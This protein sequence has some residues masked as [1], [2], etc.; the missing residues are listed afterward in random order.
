MEEGSL[1]SA[2]HKLQVAQPALSNQVKALEQVYGTRLFHRGSGS[3]RLE[4]TDAGRIL[5]EK[6]KIML[7][8]ESTARNEIANCFDGTRGSLRVGITD[9]L[10]NRFLMRALDRFAESYPD[11]EIMLHESKLPDLIKMLQ[12]GLC[13]VLLVRATNQKFDNFDVMFEREDYL[14]AAYR[15]GSFFVG[16]DAAE[17]PIPELAKFPLCVTEGQLSMLRNAFREEGATFTPKFIGSNT[18]ACLM[19]AHAG[20][21]VAL[22]PRLSLALLGYEDLPCKAIAGKTLS[23]ATLSVVTQK[24]QYRSRVVNNFLQIVADLYGKELN[25]ILPMEGKTP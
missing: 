22:V 18:N 15:K 4:L 14:L 11:T 25:A 6:S 21:G 10:E 23:A 12:S 9:S 16:N 8:A 7:E 24:K 1:T 19:W 17:V 2:S 13:E 3:H 20:N 5:Y